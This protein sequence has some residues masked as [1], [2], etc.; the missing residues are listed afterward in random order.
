ME[1]DHRFSV[2]GTARSLDDL[3]AMVEETHIDVVI[4]NE[5]LYGTDVLN[6]VEQLKQVS[7]LARLIV[8]GSLSDGLLIRDLFASG[9]SGYLYRS[10]DLECDLVTAVDTVMRDRPYLSPTANAEYLVAMQSPRRDSFLDREMRETLRLLAQGQHVGEIA[11]A[12][13]IPLRRVYWIRQKLRER[14]GAN[15]NEHMIS[16]AAQEGFLFPAD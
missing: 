16:R 11:V 7:P 14:F 10:D 6:S 8:L 1:D 3:L 12:L 13:D 4:L 5:Y 15:T 9:V 2:T